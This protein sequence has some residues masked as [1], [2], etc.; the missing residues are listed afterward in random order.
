M[1]IQLYIYIYILVG[2]DSLRTSLSKTLWETKFKITCYFS[3]RKKYQSRNEQEN[4]NWLDSHLVS[5]MV[6]WRSSQAHP[7]CNFKHLGSSILAVTMKSFCLDLQLKVNISLIR[8]L[9][10]F[11][12][13]FCVSNY[14]FQYYFLELK[15]LYKIWWHTYVLLVFT[16]KLLWTSTFGFCWVL[17]F[18]KYN[19]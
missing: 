19:W 9:F 12:F 10:L 4:V 3:D 7:L 18:L 17:F 8:C 1:C 14:M 16:H 2:R 11:L 6:T 13:F 15:I 5:P